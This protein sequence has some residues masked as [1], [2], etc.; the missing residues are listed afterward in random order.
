MTMNQK[1]LPANQDNLSHIISVL[2]HELR[3]PLN[4]IYGMSQILRKLD[5]IDN[6]VM[7]SIDV[8]YQS[9][10]DVLPILN[11]ISDFYS[12]DGTY[13]FRQEPFNL[14]SVMERLIQEIYE[15]A[16][17]KELNVFLDFQPFTLQNVMGDKKII[18]MVLTFILNNALRFTQHGEIY[19]KVESQKQDDEI[20]D[21]TI[22]IED[23]GC[24][25]E[26]RILDTLFNLFSQ[27]SQD[28]YKSSGLKLSISQD[29]INGMGGV[30]N[31][32]SKP[33]MGTR[34]SIHLPLQL[35]AQE[36]V[37][38]KVLWDTFRQCLRVLIVENNECIG[39]SLS[40]YLAVSESNVVSEENM[41]V[42]MK[43]AF[44]QR[45]PYKMIVVDECFISAY[46][47]ELRALFNS[48]P[49]RLISG[50]LFVVLSD[51]ES[52]QS[53][54]FLKDTVS[55]SVIKKPLKPSVLTRQLA[56]DWCHFKNSEKQHNTAVPFDFSPSV[57][58]VE[59]DEINIDVE[60][61]MLESLGCQVDVAYSGEEALDLVKK[62]TCHY[63]L[64]FLDIGLPGRNG[65]EIAPM[66]KESAK[67]YQMPIV[68]MTSYVSDRNIQR[69]YRSGM[70]DVIPKPATIEQLEST[71][72]QFIPNI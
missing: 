13:Q 22:T 50:C 17:E 6:Q 11:Y 9:S 26:P 65:F 60:K 59:D 45:K 24:G 56:L 10:R 3:T 68:A 23:S 7:R 47:D 40:H 38:T 55:V 30:I 27:N 33:N 14:L 54:Q 66:L 42:A 19:V 72:R 32:Q 29:L 70:V 25:I 20:A 52:S 8:I 36:T 57:L 35:Q 28:D 46:R 49:Q 61:M 15:E 48:A 5:N 58:L 71:L 44:A 21:F 41:L 12:R 43:S 34:V 4:A 53:I 37:D 39:E 31:V 67:A 69:C 2:G 64:I 62:L 18:E 51:E 16:R 63:H 1:I